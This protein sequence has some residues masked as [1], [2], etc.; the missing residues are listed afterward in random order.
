[1]DFIHHAD[2]PWVVE[3]N[4][5]YPASVEVLEL[6]TGVAAVGLHRAAF[7][8]AAGRAP[9][10]PLA[11]PAIAK[12]IL[13]ARR[14]LVMP[15]AAVR[16]FLDDVRPDGLWFADVPSAGDVIEAGWPILTILAADRS[17]SAA[18]QALVEWTAWAKRVLGTEAGSR[19]H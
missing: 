2:R 11:A 19:P 16:T 5:R 1:V 7:D 15:R 6:A 4:P 13:Y 17:P 9:L 10:F 8:P 12:G 3:V 18:A 14:Q